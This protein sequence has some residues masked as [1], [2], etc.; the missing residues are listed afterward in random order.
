ML[1]LHPGKRLVRHVDREVVI[2]IVRRLDENGSVKNS[3]RPLIG[4]ATDETV[5]L[6]EAG[7]RRPPVEGARDRDFPW[8]RFVILAECSGAVAIQSQH[9]CKRRH[10]LRADAGITW[11][12]SREFHDRAG[13][14]HVMIATRQQRSASWR[15]KRSSMKIVVTQ[16]RGRELL[17]CLHFAG[18]TKRA[19]LSEADVVQQNNDDVWSSLG[20]FDLKTRRRLG[21]TSFQFCNRRRLRL[22]HR[23][24]TPI[25]LLCVRGKW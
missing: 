12:R 17:R 20:R 24:N 16:A 1:R 2:R 3:G 14:V 11:K 5:E 6:I 8:R 10:A 19:R 4:L 15:T 21:V 13:I 25:Y 22:G 9:F 18:S 7:M 23:E